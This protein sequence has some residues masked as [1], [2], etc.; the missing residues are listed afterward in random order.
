MHLFRV[1]ELRRWLEQAGLAIVDLSASGCLS[2]TWN[3]WLEEMRGD[4]DR[5]NELLTASSCA[6][7]AV[8]TSSSTAP[9]WSMWPAWI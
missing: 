2:S 4:A 6:A 8:A 3:A 7:S 1:S 9:L 5:W